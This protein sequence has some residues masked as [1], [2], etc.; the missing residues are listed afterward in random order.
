VE[1]PARADGDRDA[2]TTVVLQARR[3]WRRHVGLVATAA[4]LVVVAGAW[5]AMKS[6]ASAGAGAST[7]WPE[8]S[9]SP[10]VAA[11]DA[12]PPTTP[13]T[14][15]PEVA[16]TTGPARPPANTRPATPATTTANAPPAPAAPRVYNTKN[17]GGSLDTET[18]KNPENLESPQ[19][20]LQ[21]DF[22]FTVNGITAVNTARIAAASATP[23]MDQCAAALASA[24]Q[25]VYASALTAGSYFC[26]R[27]DEGRT[28]RIR[29]TLADHYNDGGD[30]IRGLLY[31][32]VVWKLAGDP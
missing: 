7:P 1:A 28:A 5:Y 26:L 19:P 14:P 13:V 4:I 30:K 25:T 3:G 23:T 11:G 18:Q 17:S 32:V 16:S 2:P 29:I 27:T 10:M 20:G 15:S 24:G 9:S 6:N 31:D 21:E 8:S 12:S 22:F